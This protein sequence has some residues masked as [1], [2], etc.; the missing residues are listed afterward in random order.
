MEKCLNILVQWSLPH[1]VSL[2]SRFPIFSKLFIDFEFFRC[3]E[4]NVQILQVGWCFEIVLML[5]PIRDDAARRKSE[6]MK[7]AM[8]FLWNGVPVCLVALQ[9]SHLEFMA[10]TD[11]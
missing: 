11:I 4:K 10:H 7:P 5:N 3:P 2:R 1:C 8:K 6:A 9:L